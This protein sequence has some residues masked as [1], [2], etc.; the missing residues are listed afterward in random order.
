MPLPGMAPLGPPMMPPMGMAPPGPMVPPPLGAMPR[1]PDGMSMMPNDV[2]KGAPNMGGPPPPN[3][4]PPPNWDR[5]MGPPPP[6][7]MPPPGGP[8][9]GMGKFLVY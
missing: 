8:P 9:M 4:P 2:D 6:N 5:P 3:M 1:M 7:M